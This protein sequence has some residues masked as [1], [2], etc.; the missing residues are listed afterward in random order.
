VAVPAHQADPFAGVDF[1]ACLFKEDLFAECL[2]EIFYT[3]HNISALREPPAEKR[4]SDSW[5][6]KAFDATTIC[7]SARLLSPGVCS[8]RRSGA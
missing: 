6:D 5:R 4:P 2:P 7:L 3:N 1:K 8:V